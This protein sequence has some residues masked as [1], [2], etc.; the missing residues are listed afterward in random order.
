MERAMDNRIGL[1][2]QKRQAFAV[3]PPRRS[4]GTATP[5]VFGYQVGYSPNSTRGET[6]VELIRRAGA[7]FARFHVTWFEIEP[8]KGKFDWAGLDRLVDQVRESRNQAGDLFLRHAALG[9]EH[10]RTT[11]AT[12]S[13]SGPTTPM[14][15]KM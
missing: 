7:D 9:V 11:R 1:Y 12:S 6:E 15:P 4:D 13:T 3:I 2:E 8:E 14:R 10:A 5:P